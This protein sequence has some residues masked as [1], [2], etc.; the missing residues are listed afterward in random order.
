MNRDVPQR[1]ER[2]VPMSYPFQLFADRREF[3]GDA[4]RGISGRLVMA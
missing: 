3:F 2:L 1:Q 4:F